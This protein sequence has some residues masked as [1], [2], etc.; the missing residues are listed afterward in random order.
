[1]KRVYYWML[2]V[3]WALLIFELSSMPKIRDGIGS[4]F[5]VRKSAH[6]FVYCIL[7]FFTYLA[8]K[9]A[10]RIK[11]APLYVLAGIVP[12][13]YAVSDEIHQF[14]VPTRVCSS[15]DI[16][17]DML[18]VLIFYIAVRFFESAKRRDLFS[19]RQTS[20]F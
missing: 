20:Y 4:I 1:M 7:A 9:H 3:G 12:F 17:I 15:K 6:V 8:G 16:L 14:F 10:L 19:Q 5:I 18:G 11:G 13:L 2:V